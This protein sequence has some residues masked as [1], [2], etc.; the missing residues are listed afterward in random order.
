MR[1]QKQKQRKSGN[2]ETI[3]TE[4]GIANSKRGSFLLFI[5]SHYCQRNNWSRNVS[6]DCHFSRREYIRAYICTY[7]FAAHGAVLLSFLKLVDQAENRFSMADDQVKMKKEIKQKTGFR[8]L[9]A[10]EC[11]LKLQFTLTVIDFS[12][13]F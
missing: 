9:M 10:V 11:K 4:R 8:F 13:I 12:F 5:F 7:E 6:N 3:V 2:F 1:K